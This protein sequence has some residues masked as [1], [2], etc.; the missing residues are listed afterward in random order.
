MKKFKLVLIVLFIGVMGSALYGCSNHKAVR[1]VN[2]YYKHQNKM[3]K[4]FEACNYPTTK[5]AFKK[6]EATNYGKNCINAFYAASR[7]F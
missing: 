7:M 6:F 1:S 5:A 2:Y 3:R 4:V